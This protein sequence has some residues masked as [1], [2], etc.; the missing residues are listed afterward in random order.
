[1]KE[2]ILKLIELE[3]TRFEGLTKER[4]RA[5]SINNIIQLK[6]H[7]KIPELKA[8]TYIDAKNFIYHYILSLKERQFNYDEFDENCL[9]AL[10]NHFEVEERC[11]LLNFTITTIQSQH[12]PEKAESFKN[13]LN[14]QELHKEWK[15]LNWRNIFTIVFKASVYNNYTIVLSLLICFLFSFIIY[16]PAPTGWPVLFNIHYHK[17]SDNFMINHAG[18]VLLG[19]FDLQQDKFVLPLSFWGSILLI[20]MRCFFLLIIVNVFI[21]QIKQRFKF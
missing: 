19:L 9:H 11:S 3:N 1:L 5:E 20:F 6:L 8:D 15:S 12:L 17:I 21:E 13:S 10:I 4:E 7:S 14:Q 18:N 2:Q 16:L